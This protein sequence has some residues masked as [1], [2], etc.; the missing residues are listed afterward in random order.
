MKKR[1]VTR[2]K[3]KTAEEYKQAVLDGIDSIPSNTVTITADLNKRSVNM[4]K[5]Y[6]F[7]CNAIAEEEG[8]HHDAVHFDL[9]CL[10]LEVVNGA[11]QVRT[12]VNFKTYGD[13]PESADLIPTTTGLS[14]EDFKSYW[15]RCAK[16]GNALYDMNLPLNP[17]EMGEK[18][19]INYLAS[20]V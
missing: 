7:L 19:Y 3:G 17:Y 9:K 8:R 5:F 1:V 2:S 13:M 12:E 11:T 16:L 14:K 6:R 20:T 10:C 15:Q 4:N 18:D